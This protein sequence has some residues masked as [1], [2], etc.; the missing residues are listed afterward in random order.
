MA[1]ASCSSL[2][3]GMIFAGF[4]HGQ[5]LASSAVVAVAVEQTAPTPPAV[6]PLGD[7]PFEISELGP[8]AVV[9]TSAPFA[10]N[11]L[12]V[13]TAQGAVILVDTPT[14]PSN[15]AA[16]LDFS[17]AYF[18]TIPRFAIASHWHADA[19]GGNEVLLARGVELIS[20]ERTA[21]LIREHGR[22]QQ[23]RLA[24][25]FRARKPEL[26]DELA[27]VTPTPAARTVTVAE[28]TDLQLAGETVALVYPGP[29]HSSD[30]IGIYFP[31]LQLLYGGCTI[32]SDGRIV[33]RDGAD[34]ANWPQAVRTLQ[35]LGAT[36]VVP[37]HGRRFDVAMFDESV[38]AALDAAQEEAA[39]RGAN[40]VPAVSPLEHQVA[41]D[42]GHVM[43]VHGRSADS[44]WGVVLLV[45]GRTWSP[46]SNP[47][48]PAAGGVRPLHEH[49]IGCCT[50]REASHQGQIVVILSNADH[51]AILETARFKVYHSL[52]SFMRWLEK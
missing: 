25:W 9:L 18:G 3:V 32:R 52:I 33:N 14:G 12:L 36:V 17:E 50:V 29:A 49:G 2:V 4:A 45:H 15:T 23:Q 31:S 10:A 41:M 8:H 47:Y 42:D 7:S 51:A 11:S 48:A 43:T 24:D 20:S 30:S 26:A 28:R 39:K 46:S 44:P 22:G 13:R 19:S 16:L 1:R 34:L 27:S 37:G 40:G 6:R 35:G 5:P 38:Q 21:R